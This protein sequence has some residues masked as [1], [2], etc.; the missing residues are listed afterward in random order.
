[1]AGPFDLTGQNIED[2]YQRILQT[3]GTNIYNGTGSLFS[4]PS[5][6]PYT[7]SALITGSLG[8]TGSVS[9]NG[10]TGTGLIS[11]YGDVG[12]T[13]RLNVG[14]SNPNK[15]QFTQEFTPG[16]PT[17][18][19]FVSNE[20]GTG[21]ILSTFQ[22]I[23]FKP[24]NTE[25]AKFVSAT[26]NFLIG[27][28]TDSARL[29]VK[30]SGTTSATNNFSITDSADTLL[31]R[32]N[33]LGH[34]TLSSNQAS[35]Q[36]KFFISGYTTYPAL[37]ITSGATTLSTIDGGNLALQGGLIQFYNGTGTTEWG[38]FFSNGNLLI[39]TGGTYTD[40]GYKLDVSG[41]LRVQNNS[42]NTFIAS[43][44][45]ISTRADSLTF[46]T[47]TNSYYGIVLTPSNSDG[48]IRFRNSNT[49]NIVN[50]GRNFNFYTS[51]ANTSYVGSAFMFSGGTRVVAGQSANSQWNI[52]YIS[53]SVA[54]P[55]AGSG[56]YNILNIGGGIDQSGGGNGVTRGLY[57]NPTLTSTP[58][59]RA[60]ET[61]TGSVVFDGGSVGIGTTS[62]L[63]FKLVVQGGI[64]VRSSTSNFVGLLIGDQSIRRRDTGTFALGTNDSATAIYMFAPTNN[65]GINTATDAG[66][67]LDVSGSTRVSG[68]STLQGAV[69]VNSTNVSTGYALFVNGVIGATS[70]TLTQNLTMGENYAI[71]NNGSQTI[72]IDANNDSTNAVFR[73]TANGTANELFRVNETGSFGIGTTTP[74]YKLDVSGS[75]RIT[76]GLIISSSTTINDQLVI[77]IPETDGPIDDTRPA[78]FYKAT[79]NGAV[80]FLPYY[81]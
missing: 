61:T 16:T 15:L 36:A 30:G 80:V 21:M 66:Y 22:D 74:N 57:V 23:I 41:S 53:A 24:G 14:S 39:Q 42:L 28:T 77:N 81:L 12:S 60:I 7:G 71:S 78:G 40:A 45:A 76:N 8:V 10:R 37:N 1:M 62:S 69:A 72:D 18:I 9:V 34:I 35:K 59:F 33:D 43:A 3:D 44:G 50:E 68:T 64:Q 6:F 25:R 48:E 52:F 55:N 17:E 38:R 13:L 51:N 67:K 54:T 2:T 20:W 32:I 26:G 73:V 75:A 58:D 5:A 63:F 29:T 27:T 70:V 79:V 4:I 31:F 11:I 19:G 56:S 49:A 46:N 65:V 47:T